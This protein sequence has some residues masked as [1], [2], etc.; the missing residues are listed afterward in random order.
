MN[1]SFKVTIEFTS[2]DELLDF[3]DA[4]KRIVS[5][6]G[7]LEDKIKD[8][9]FQRRCHANKSK[10]WTEYEDNIIITEYHKHPSRWIANA[11]GRTPTSVQQRIFLLR[12]QRKIIHGKNN[13]PGKVKVI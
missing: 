6:Q 10:P 4:D 9:P 13:K 12:K 11:L 7:Y 1:K 3:L 8:I 5:G 2:E